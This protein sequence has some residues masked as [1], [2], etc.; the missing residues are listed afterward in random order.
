MTIK[1]GDHTFVFFGEDV[2]SLTVLES[3]VNSRLGLRPLAV[4]VLEPISVSGMRLVTF[5][6]NHN[7]PVIRTQSVHSNKFLSYFDGMMIDFMICTHF[8][9]LLPEILFGQA[10]LG[11][12]NLHPSLLPRY[13]GMSPQHWPIIYGD[14]ET[15]VTVH[16]ID[17]GV[18]TGRILRQV[19][20]PLEP[21]IYIHELQ[22]KLLNVYATVM[23]EAVE[24]VIAGE[25]GLIQTT[26]DASYFH[27]ICD[28]D[29]EITNETSVEYAG[30][31]VRAFS[32]PYAGARFG[33][34][35]IMRA[36]RI[37]DSTWHKLRGM[38]LGL[39]FA[40]DGNQNF[41]ILKD[42]ALKVTKWK[43]I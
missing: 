13:R 37:D 11:A 15:G 6:I 2:F 24:K 12:L 18:D 14:A 39:G 4:V 25:M 21:N 30:N 34:V 32:F 41:L 3:L 10:R 7:I 26:K 40:S 27:R 36:E 22:K 31:I 35:R 28:G 17:A 23:L 42:G 1:R 20:I 5:C 33:T 43:K 16:R 38:R 19:E 8:Q 9:R 29:M